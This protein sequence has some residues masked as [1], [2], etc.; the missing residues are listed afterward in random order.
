MGSDGKSMNIFER[1]LSIWVALCMVL[2]VAVGKLFPN[3][4]EAVRNLEFGER[5][6]SICRSRC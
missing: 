1:Y 6:T 4:V 5:A 2:G 3:L